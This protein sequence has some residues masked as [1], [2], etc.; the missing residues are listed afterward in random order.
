MVTK[1]S[2][3]SAMQGYKS[4]GICTNQTNYFGIFK[5]HYFPRKKQNE[6][7]T[8]LPFSPT[9]D[10]FQ[11]RF[12]ITEFYNRSIPKAN[13]STFWICL[14]ISEEKLKAIEHQK[15]A[16]L[17]SLQE[18]GSSFGDGPPNPNDSNGQSQVFNPKMWS[19]PKSMVH[20]MEG[21]VNL[22]KAI[23]CFICLAMFSF[24]L[25]YLAVLF[26]QVKYPPR[27]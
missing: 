19:N 9:T 1:Y 25:I 17:L 10:L 26:A 22:T 4:T 3:K 14:L 8:F 2:K 23:T 18:Q 5:P 12:L 7:R 15:Q 24:I 6:K 21:L 20:E 11:I 27:N 16:R 13:G